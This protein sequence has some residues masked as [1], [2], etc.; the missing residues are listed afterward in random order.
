MSESIITYISNRQDTFIYKI[1]LI[2]N[3]FV[4]LNYVKMNIDIR[5][6][7]KQK[8]WN[9]KWSKTRII[10]LIIPSIEKI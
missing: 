1:N 2:K 7:Y 4:I 6:N 3:N 8:I 10:I 9:I 5:W